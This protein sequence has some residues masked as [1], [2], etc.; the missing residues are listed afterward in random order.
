MQLVGVRISSEEELEVVIFWYERHLPKHLSH[1]RDEGHVVGSEASQ[2]LG[3]SFG[4][5]KRESFRETPVDVE[6]LA[7]P[8]KTIHS[9]LVVDESS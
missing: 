2:S 4:V 8:S 7:E 1:V 9:L 3:K 5:T 6:L